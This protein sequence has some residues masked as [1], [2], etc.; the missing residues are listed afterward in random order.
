MTSRVSLQ[1][2]TRHAKDDSQLTSATSSSSQ[3]DVRS[4]HKTGS[5][6]GRNDDKDDDVIFVGETPRKTSRDRSPYHASSGSHTHARREHGGTSASGMPSS[7]SRSAGDVNRRHY[8]GSGSRERVHTAGAPRQV[9]IETKQKDVTSPQD[10]RSARSHHLGTPSSNSQA[11]VS[12]QPT[13]TASPV[14]LQNTHSHSAHTAQHTKGSSANI[15][16]NSGAS[17]ENLVQQQTVN[18]SPLNK[19]ATTCQQPQQPQQPQQQQQQQTPAQNTQQP[20]TSH[21]TETPDARGKNLIMIVCNS[22]IV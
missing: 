4:N 5:C 13:A 9:V 16:T 7:R 12:T 3:R 20:V 19:G 8:S 22:Q 6:F 21:R 17:V 15:L 18:A 10:A 11:V 1:I 2:I 14:S